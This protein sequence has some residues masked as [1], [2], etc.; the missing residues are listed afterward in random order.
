MKRITIALPAL[1]AAAILTLSACGGGGGSTPSQSSS[2]APSGAATMA[3]PAA[4]YCVQQGGTLDLASG[5]CTL[6]NG[7]KVDEWE[8]YRSA[9]PDQDTGSSDTDSD[10]DNG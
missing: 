4:E 9:H 5:M 8:L 7:T 10:S 3:N 1:A 6:P 2:T